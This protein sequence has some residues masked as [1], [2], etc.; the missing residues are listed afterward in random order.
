MLLEAS[1]LCK[2]SSLSS[3]LVTQ[4]GEQNA[5]A[6]RDCSWCGLLLLVHNSKQ[7]LLSFEALLV[8]L[9]SLLHSLC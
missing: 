9:L 8:M 7:L 3:Q 1:C 6:L 5:I 2:V 4:V